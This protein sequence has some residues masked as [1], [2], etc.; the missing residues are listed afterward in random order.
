MEKNEPELELYVAE[1]QS[2][3]QYFATNKILI[4]RFLKRNP[5]FKLRMQTV[6]CT[7]EAWDAL[8]ECAQYGYTIH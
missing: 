4:E 1:T 6:R 2:G 3:R 8:C 7:Q 5:N